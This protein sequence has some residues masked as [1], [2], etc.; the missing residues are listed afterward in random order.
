MQEISKFGNNEA[1]NLETSGELYTDDKVVGM[2]SSGSSNGYQKE[3][4][5]EDYP[6]PLSVLGTSV[7][8]DLSPSVSLFFLCYTLLY[9]ST[10]VFNQI[11]KLFFHLG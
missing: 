4:A 3:K 1:S 6:L 2:P 5:I 10:L 8:Y 7:L 9:C 11:F